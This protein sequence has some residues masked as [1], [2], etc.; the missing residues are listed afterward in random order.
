MTYPISISLKDRLGTDVS[1]RAR[2]ASL[3]SAVVG[4][5]DA[6]RTHVTIDLDGV[7]SI[8]ESFADELFGVLTTSKGEVWF[9]KH[10][11][12]VNLSD[13]LRYSILS[14]INNRITSGR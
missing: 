14:A 7:C 2:A 4:L 10:I 12:L 3:R 13:D 6:G 8:S 9:K 11:V 1:S 5:I